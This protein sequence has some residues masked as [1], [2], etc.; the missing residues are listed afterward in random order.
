MKEGKFLRDHSTIGITFP[1]ISIDYSV[2]STATREILSRGLTVAIST[3]ENASPIIEK[4]AVVTFPLN[5]LL[6][7]FFS[8]SGVLGARYGLKSLPD[9]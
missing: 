1:S 5:V 8:L 3:I 2:I 9:R 7:P 4:A 6:V